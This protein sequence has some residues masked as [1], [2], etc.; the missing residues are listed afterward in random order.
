MGG[1]RSFFRRISVVTTLLALAWV[2][3]TGCSQPSPSNPS[4]GGAKDRLKLVMIPK[5]TQASFWNAVRKGAEQ[6]AEE[7]EVDLTWKGPAVDND[8]AAQKEVAQRFVTG[9]D[10][11]LL[12]PTDSIALA[13]TARTAMKQGTPVMIFDSALQGKLGEEFIGYV[14][15]DNLAAGR[16]GGKHV[17]ELVGNGGKVILFRHMEGQESTSARENGA[18]EEFRAANA[19]ILV[20]DRYTGQT[21]GEAQKTALNMID[22]IRQADGIFAS[23][24]TSSEGLLVALQKN[25]LAG[26]V[27]FV[28]FDSSPM[29]VKALAAGEIDGLVV[30]DPVNMGHTAVSLMVDHIGGKKIEPLV[31]TDCHLATRENMDDPKIKPLLE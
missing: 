26:K 9:V 3:S 1:Q 29:L 31:S 28:G 8:R 19:N 22:T 14:A 12:A 17:M 13:P 7:L 25:N 4:K 11:L 10:G 16:M 18:L 24:Q 20:E 27:K 21:A 23:N 30:Q 6:A 15:T 5:A 2:V